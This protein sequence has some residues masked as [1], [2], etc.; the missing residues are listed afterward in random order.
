MPDG[1]VIIATDN[2]I[3]GCGNT[4]PR[5]WR[6]ARPSD[7]SSICAISPRPRNFVYVAQ[8]DFAPC[9]DGK[10]KGWAIARPVDGMKVCAASPIPPGFTRGARTQETTCPGFGDNAYFLARLQPANE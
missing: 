9:P 2:F 10:P 4:N 3:V 7:V 8:D 1:Y 6:I 5:G